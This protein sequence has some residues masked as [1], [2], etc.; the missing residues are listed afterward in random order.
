MDELRPPQRHVTV[1]EG[2]FGSELGALAGA[3]RL[4]I[5]LGR[6]APPGNIHVHDTEVTLPPVRLPLQFARY[7]VANTAIP[8]I[9]IHSIRQLPLRRRQEP[10]AYGIRRGRGSIRCRESGVPGRGAVGL[11]AQLGG[12]TWVRFGSCDRLASRSWLPAYMVRDFG[13]WDQTRGQSNGKHRPLLHLGAN[14]PE[15]VAI[16]AAGCHSPPRFISTRLERCAL[17]RRLTRT[18]SLL[19]SKPNH[20]SDCGKMLV[21]RG[22]TNGG[23]VGWMNIL[24]ISRE[25]WGEG[26]KVVEELEIRAG[27]WLLQ[28]C[29]VA[30]SLWQPS[31]PPKRVRNR[32]QQTRVSNTY[33]GRS[34]RSVRRW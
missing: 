5:T 11:P 22:A 3:L 7:G 2:L 31:P 16:A 15:L 14:L 21:R 18:G 6:F 8:V 33:S 29:F 17:W 1:L 23:G 34:R 10:K 26:H 4:G 19:T 9:T 32:A 20:I 13:T 30:S 28:Y 12:G 25:T 24:G 27:V